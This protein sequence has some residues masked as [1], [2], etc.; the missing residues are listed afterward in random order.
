MSPSTRVIT[1]HLHT[2]DCPHLA[3]YFL[4]LTQDYTRPHMSFRCLTSGRL[5][6]NTTLPLRRSRTVSPKIAIPN[7]FFLCY[8]VLCLQWV[9]LSNICLSLSTIYFPH[10]N[11]NW[12][13]FQ[14]GKGCYIL[15]NQHNA[16][17]LRI[18]VCVKYSIYVEWINKRCIII[19]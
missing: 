5:V 1:Y 3:L 10:K 2:S 4:T 17:I 18:K 16:L 8:T 11:V 9:L 12:W 14:E 15:N 7:P 6:F 19:F 13:K